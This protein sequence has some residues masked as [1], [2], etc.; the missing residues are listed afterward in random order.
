MTHLN[1]F[2]FTISFVGMRTC[3]RDSI[4]T[5]DVK[6]HKSTLSEIYSLA[7]KHKSIF[8]YYSQS[9]HPVSFLHAAQANLQM[10]NLSVSA[11]CLFVYGLVWFWLAV[12]WLCHL[13]FV[14]CTQTIYSF[15]VASSFPANSAQS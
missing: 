10:K 2:P 4:Y 12:E 7:N 5:R 8:I 6:L 15:S 11:M 3:R 1:S 13:P 14:V 9:V